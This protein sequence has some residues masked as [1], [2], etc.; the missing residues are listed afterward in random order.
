[1]E[2]RRQIEAEINAAIERMLAQK[3]FNGNRPSNAIMLD[4]LNPKISK[5]YCSL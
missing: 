5:A 4:E 1:M 3:Q 2:S